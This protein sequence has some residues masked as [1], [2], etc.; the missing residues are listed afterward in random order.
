MEFNTFICKEY[1]CG[2]QL[3]RESHRSTRLLQLTEGYIYIYIYIYI[4]KYV[5]PTCFAD[6]TSIFICGN[7][8][9]TVQANVDT[10]VKQLLRWF[11]K[12]DF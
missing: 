4:V 10:T 8:I 7:N 11:E 9:N 2:L 5:K 3:P 1:I 12:I 6:D